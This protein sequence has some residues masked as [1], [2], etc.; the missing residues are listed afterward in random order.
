MIVSN[1]S[2]ARPALGTVQSRLETGG[3][4]TRWCTRPSSRFVD[5]ERRAS[6]AAAAQ[7][8][9]RDR[10]A[11]ATRMKL[12]AR[13]ALAHAA[14]FQAPAPE[15]AHGRIAVTALVAGTRGTLAPGRGG[16]GL[17]NAIARRRRGWRDDWRRSLRRG[18]R[19]A[20]GAQTP[21]EQ[22]HDS[23]HAG[24]HAQIHSIHCALRAP[25]S[26]VTCRLK[27]F[28]IAGGGLLS[29][30]E[31]ATGLGTFCVS[32]LRP[33]PLCHEIARDRGT[34]CPAWLRAALVEATGAGAAVN[35][36]R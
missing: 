16:A 11:I 12:E 5:P 28:A 25:A 32:L 18:C 36:G 13:V 22:N 24:L 27:R 33:A 4:R 29:Y 8:S 31:A 34:R 14:V 10:L 2:Q 26:R 9:I 23:E 7:F 1:R 3:E 15:R 35:G 20:T 6:D 19:M 21:G 17:R 30:A